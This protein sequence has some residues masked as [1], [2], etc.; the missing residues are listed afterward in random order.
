M[1]SSLHLISLIPLT[2]PLNIHL[3]EPLRRR[4]GQTVLPGNKSMHDAVTLPTLGRSPLQLA[5]K[6]ICELTRF[7]NLL[8]DDVDDV[9]KNNHWIL[10]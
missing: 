2:L 1:S 5:F 3:S 10:H 9:G 4:L 7:V 6:V 8:T